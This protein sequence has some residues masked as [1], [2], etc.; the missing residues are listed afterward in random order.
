MTM[1]KKG[2]IIFNSFKGELV[3]I[4][5]AK[6]DY[7]AHDKPIG[8]EQTELWEKE[9]W[10]VNAEYHDLETPIIY[11][12]F[13]E[14]I[15]M[16]QGEKYA[17]FNKIGR[18]NTG[19]LFRVTPELAEYLFTIVEEENGN[20]RDNL[21]TIESKDEETILEEIEKDLPDVL[22]QTEKEQIIKSRIGHS[23]F[24]KNLLKNEK[25]CKLCGVSD[26]RFLIASHIKPWSK[27]NHKERL[28]INNGLLL[29]PNHDALF[30]KGYI[31]FGDD[32]EILISASLDESLK[33]FLNV[34]DKLQ[35][36]M[37]E[38]QRQYMKWHREIEFQA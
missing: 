6:E 14:N 9:G 15:L 35:I 10:I 34:N 7:K 20:I 5:V 29:C 27:S 32:G 36:Q 31:S 26:K 30:D 38:M 21:S 3:S 28:D 2:D 12:N 18:G 17:P 25:K 19:Y 22:D 16:L 13:I 24:K 11:K 1:I 37:N 23:I 4:L 33:I 8:L